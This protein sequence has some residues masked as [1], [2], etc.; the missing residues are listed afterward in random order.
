M[1]IDRKIINDLDFQGVQK[2]KNAVDGTDP[3]DY[4]TVAQLGGGT[5]SV[6]FGTPAPT[7]ST[8]D[9][10]GSSGKAMQSDAT[11]ALF[12][13]AVPV[14][15][16]FGDSASAGTVAF[17]PRLD[18]KHAM[19]ANPL[20]ETGGPTTLAFGAVANGE[21]LTRSGSSIIG[22]SPTP[23]GPPTG[24][25]GGALD[26]TYPNPGLAAAV[27]GAGLAET[28]D[29]LSVNVDASTIEIVTDTLQ[30]KDAGIT[31]AKLAASAATPTDG[32]VSDV[33]HTW[34]YAS[35]STFTISGVDLTAVFTPGTRLKFTQT[36][37]KYGT[38]A[39]SSFSTNTTVTI[40]VNTDHVLANAAISANY[41]SYDANPRGY[42][43]WFTY[44][45]GP[46]GFSGTPTQRSS[47]FSAVGRACSVFLDVTGTS[48][49]NAFTLALPVAAQRSFVGE[50]SPGGN[51]A[52][53][54]VNALV[55]SGSAPS[56]TL[57]LFSNANAAV[58]AT[59]GTKSVQTQFTYEF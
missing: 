16:A 35:A 2:V 52:S 31:T 46:T 24:A 19:P 8:A 22:G 41:Y 30:V 23:G 38:V 13:V 32:W 25:A 47:R 54:G 20:I 6:S 42:P 53:G 9:A 11:L 48:N 39:S 59:S 40:I 15:Q 5:S 37:V 58:W 49:T 57:T 12:N 33:A 10:I 36:T 34:T 43:G 26:G 28:S 44:D 1:T 50:I 29:V 4:A 56:S 14:T 51:G 45:C 7:W 18:H 27:A 55:Q 3:Q 21:Y 17:A